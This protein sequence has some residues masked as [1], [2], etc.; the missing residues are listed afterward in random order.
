MEN[1]IKLRRDNLRGPKELFLSFLLNRFHQIF[2]E[3]FSGVLLRLLNIYRKLLYQ[4]IQE[5]E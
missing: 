1:F 3:A 4:S 5:D 2:Q